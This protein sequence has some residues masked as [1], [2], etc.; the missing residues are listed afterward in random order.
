M[1]KGETYTLPVVKDED[2]DKLLPYATNMTGKPSEIHELNE[3]RF[4]IET[5][6]RVKNK[7]FVKTCSKK[8]SVRYAFLVFAFALYNLWV[9]LNILERGKE[10]LDPGKILIKVD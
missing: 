10:G 7:F 5:Q 3:H 4:G 9:L 1:S 8:Y 2:T 6:N